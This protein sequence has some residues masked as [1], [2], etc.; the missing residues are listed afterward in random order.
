M[1]AVGVVVA[2]D[3]VKDFQARVGGVFKAAALEHLAFEGADEGLCPGVAV[4]VGARR[5]AL[6]HPGTRQGLAEGGAAI[7]AA[8]VAVEDRVFCP[9][10]AESLVQGSHDQ[11][12]A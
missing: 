10:G 5:H 9:T 1:F 2:F 3:V 6:A 12:A 4:G 7:L 11:V 8:P